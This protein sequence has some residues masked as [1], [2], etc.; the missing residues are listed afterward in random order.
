MYHFLVG[1]GEKEIKTNRSATPTL[2][3]LLQHLLYH[4]LEHR[5]PLRE[6]IK[7]VVENA[8]KIWQKFDFEIRRSDNIEAALIKEYNDY[9]Q[10]SKNQA[11]KTQEQ[12]ERRAEFVKKL[13]IPFNFKKQNPK[14][15]FD[16][17]RN[18][19]SEA[20]TSTSQVVETRLRPRESLQLVKQPSAASIDDVKGKLKCP[21]VFAI[22]NC[23]YE[24]RHR[25]FVIIIIIID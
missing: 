21:T 6:S 18:I 7:L 3:V 24:I 23:N 9:L 16:V 17:D 19:Q 10:I 15:S 11:S 14:R 4:H 25:C 12:R 13:D 22:H 5:K 1:I 2:R 20:S 8:M